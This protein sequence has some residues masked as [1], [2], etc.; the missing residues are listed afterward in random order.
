MR[1]GG[2]EWGKGRVGGERGGWVGRKGEGGRRVGG[3]KGEK[4]N[5]KGKHKIS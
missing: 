4:E 5:N 1:V 2:G 3:R